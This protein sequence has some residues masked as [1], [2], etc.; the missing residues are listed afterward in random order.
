[1]VYLKGLALCLPSLPYAHCWKEEGEGEGPFCFLS[2]L[3][4][5][6][7]CLPWTTSPILLY[8]E[9]KPLRDGCFK[10]GWENRWRGFRTTT[11][12]LRREGFWEL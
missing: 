2:L 12:V 8:L 1:M 10:P 11:P 3:A 6:P 5:L 9:K 7:A 4:C